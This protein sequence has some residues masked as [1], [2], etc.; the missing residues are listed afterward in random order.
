MHDSTVFASSVSKY[1][2]QV[3][4]QI[5]NGVFNIDKPM[6]PTFNM[7]GMPTG[8]SPTSSTNNVIIN[9]DIAVHGGNPKE[10]AA[11]VM[12]QL[13]MIQ[14]KAGGKVRF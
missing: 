11:E 1:G 14:R 5:N 9:A 6:S 4:D 7:P 3:L 13:D 12:K 8:A 10:A 2:K